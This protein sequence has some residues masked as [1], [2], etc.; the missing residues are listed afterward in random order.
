[1]LQGNLNIAFQR[2]KKTPTDKGVSYT[3]DDPWRVL[4]DIKGTPRFYQKKK[5]EFI[6][7]LENLGP[8]TIFLTLS[9][10][11]RRWSENFT[12]LLELQGHTLELSNEWEEV[13]VDGI[14][15]TEFIAQNEG[16]HEEAQEPGDCG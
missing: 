9:C 2:G 15:L 7:K 13:R 12:S 4:D 11:D 3:L 16:Q 6:A 10:G 8:F 1:M 5:M 14:P